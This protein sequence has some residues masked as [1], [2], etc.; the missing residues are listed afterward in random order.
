MKPQKRTSP[1]D[2]RD[3][4]DNRP[5]DK[6][7]DCME[8]IPPFRLQEGEEL[9]RIS[10]RPVKAQPADESSTT[11]RALQ[12]MLEKLALQA[13]EDGGRSHFARLDLLTIIFD[14]VERMNQLV[15]QHPERWRWIAATR[16][17]WP[18]NA[19]LHPRYIKGMDK[20]AAI[21]DFLEKTLHLGEN[22]IPKSDLY[23][24]TKL[25]SPIT[26]E[27]I[28]LVNHVTTARGFVRYLPPELKQQVTGWRLAAGNL[29]HDYSKASAAQ[30]ADVAIKA[31]LES[32]PHPEQT[33]LNAEVGKR[34]L[35][36]YERLRNVPLSQLRKATADDEEPTH[37]ENAERIGKRILYRLHKT[38]CELAVDRPT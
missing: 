26:R 30:W 13:A 37:R 28:R 38:I 2:N 12:D 27:A 11:K 4:R 16:P 36:E 5:A 17:Q 15:E 19:S 21:R 33:P 31:F 9:V 24:K 1:R 20:G 6:V 32:Y 22:T 7:F 3:D 34:K 14:A 29:E 23:A 18:V 8:F 10:P 25:T 35:A